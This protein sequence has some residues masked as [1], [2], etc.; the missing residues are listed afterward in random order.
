MLFFTKTLSWPTVVHLK[1]I[2]NWIN[3]VN[4]TKLVQLLKRECSECTQKDLLY[5]LERTQKSSQYHSECKRKDLQYQELTAYFDRVNKE[6]CDLLLKTDKQEKEIVK[7]DLDTKQKDSDVA[8]EL[9]TTRRRAWKAEIEYEKLSRQVH[10]GRKEAAEADTRKTWTIA[11]YQ[12]LLECSKEDLQKAR[13]EIQ[14]VKDE[15]HKARNELHKAEDEIRGLKSERQEAKE[16]HKTYV[17][18]EEAREKLQKAKDEAKQLSAE[19]ETV[20]SELRTAKQ[21]L[22]KAVVALENITKHLGQIRP[23]STSAYANRSSQSSIDK[24][25]TSITGSREFSESDQNK[26]L[27]DDDE[28][29][30][31]AI[32]KSKTSTTGKAELSESSSRPLTTGK[33]DLSTTRND[34]SSA[35]DEKKRMQNNKSGSSSTDNIIPLASSTLPKVNG[36]PKRRP[37]GSFNIPRRTPKKPL[38]EELWEEEEKERATF[39]GFIGPPREWNPTVVNWDAQTRLSYDHYNF[40]LDR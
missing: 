12:D 8:K 13:M 28:N 32:G 6:R 17:E 2:I 21:E 26:P 14:M 7:L 37:K 16:M 5:R 19:S 33:S 40:D 34:E 20:K 30:L 22:G 1:R 38:F 4:W 25:F 3:K 18:S 23:P 10:E 15:F 35:A 36:L 39:K 31:P 11:I 24:C 27:Q 29:V 9:S